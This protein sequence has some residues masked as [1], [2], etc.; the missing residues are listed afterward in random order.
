MNIEYFMYVRK[1]MESEEKQVMSIEA[2]HFELNEFARREKIKIIGIFEESKSAK[3]PVR[4]E[5]NKMLAQIQLSKKPIGIISWHPDRLARNSVDGGQIIYLV[6][7]GKI[8]SLRFPTFWFEAT[9]Q[10]KFMLQV[11]FGQSKY[12]S[13]SLSVNVKRGMRQK[14]RRGE[15]ANKPPLGYMSNLKTKNIEPDPVKGKIIQRL[16]AEFAE[17]KHSMKTA[18]ERLY[19]WGITSKFGGL[20][21]NSAMHWILTNPLYFGIIRYDG[22]MYEG[23]YEPIISRETFDKVQARLKEKSRPRKSNQKHDFA[24]TGLFT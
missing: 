17:G 20:I 23:K 21:S 24:F 10:G 9:P 2:Q 16:F 13:D 4:T 22:E 6:D 14:L 11:A 3:D 1:S 7:T 19:F 18:N 15:W 12:Y 5:F 8:C